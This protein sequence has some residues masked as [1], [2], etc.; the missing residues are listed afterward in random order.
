[1]WVAELPALLPASGVRP[2]E[3][4]SVIQTGAVC[5][6]VNVHLTVLSLVA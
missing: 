2:L 6:L 5:T 3:A 1:M 4:L